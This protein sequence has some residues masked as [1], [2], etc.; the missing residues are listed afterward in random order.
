MT[1]LFEKIVKDFRMSKRGKGSPPREPGE[2]FPRSK[3]AAVSIK[4]GVAKPVA[5]F[6]WMLLTMEKK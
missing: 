4:N 2:P 6:G 5:P 1:Y 3:R